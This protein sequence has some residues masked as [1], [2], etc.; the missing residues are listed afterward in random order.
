M[1]N[2]QIM[3]DLESWYDKLKVAGLEHFRQHS[4]IVVITGPSRIR[5]IAMEFVMGMHEPRVPYVFI[6][7]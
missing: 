4:N 5:D 6:H 1:T 3:P 2:D 7:R